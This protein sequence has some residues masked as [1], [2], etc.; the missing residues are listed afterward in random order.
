MNEEI[1]MNAA[2]REWMD[3]CQHCGDMFKVNGI[4]K[5]GDFCSRWCLDYSK[6]QEQVDR[7][8]EKLRKDKP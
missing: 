5:Y 6:Y 1:W 2:M 3:T 8:Y 7:H 4:R